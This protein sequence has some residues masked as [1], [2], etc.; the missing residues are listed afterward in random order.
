MLVSINPMFFTGSHLID[1]SATIDTIGHWSLEM[2]S[3]PCFH[4]NILP[5]YFLYFWPLLSLCKY[6]FLLSSINTKHLS[7]LS[8]RPSF[9]PILPPWYFWIFLPMPK[10]S[11]LHHD[12]YHGHQPQ[13]CI[14]AQATCLLLSELSEAPQIQCVYNWTHGLLLKTAFSNGSIS[15]NSYASQKPWHFIMS[16]PS[17]PHFL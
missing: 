17:S 10:A 13:P 5:I 12:L 1:F 15:V 2:L 6:I 16:C 7:K 3:S 14:W 9:F 8:P 4:D 11:P